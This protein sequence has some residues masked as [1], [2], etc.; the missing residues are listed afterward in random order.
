MDVAENALRLVGRSRERL[1]VGDVELDRMDALAQATYRRSDR[2][3]SR[4]GRARRSAITTFIPAAANA[5]AMPRPI[6]LAPPVTNAVLPA[7]SSALPVARPGGDGRGLPRPPALLDRQ[8]LRG[9][10]LVGERSEGLI[11][12]LPQLLSM[13]G[14]GEDVEVVAPDRAEDLLA[15]LVRVHSRLVETREDRA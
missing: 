2:G 14:V 15:D 3:R 7:T 11:E 8:P 12:D 4:R 10:R 6:P 5:S 1:A 13:V 9:H